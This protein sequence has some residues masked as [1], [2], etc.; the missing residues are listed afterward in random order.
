MF[1]KTILGTY[2][3]V[4]RRLKAK[5]LSASSRSVGR[6]CFNVLYAPSGYLRQTLKPLKIKRPLFRKLLPGGSVEDDGPHV[7][8]PGPCCGALSQVISH[9]RFG[10]WCRC[11][12]SC[13]VLY[14][15]RHFHPCSTDEDVVQKVDAGVRALT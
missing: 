9:Q 4:S 6:W 15:A 1:P 12:L 2:L 14:V 8:L 10:R 3:L 7:V 13:T 5:K 11:L